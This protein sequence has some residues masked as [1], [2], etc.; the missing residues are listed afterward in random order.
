MARMGLR[1]CRRSL[2]G[3]L[4]GSFGGRIMGWP[5]VSGF[6][7]MLLSSLLALL[8]WRMLL[9]SLLSLLRVR[10][11]GLARLA[12]LVPVLALGA[13]LRG[14]MRAAASIAV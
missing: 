3:M 5:S 6:W 10:L 12:A 13:S 11:P 1:L 14:P 8:R 7:R 4:V 2:M 9:A